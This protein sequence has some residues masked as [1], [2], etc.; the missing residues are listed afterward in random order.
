M[1]MLT[2]YAL[3]WLG[4]H[5]GISGTGLRGAIVGRIGPNA[6][7]GGFALAGLVILVML[8]RSYAT[9]PLVLMW[10]SPGWLRWV[11]AVVMLP[12]F[13]LFALSFARNPTSAGGDKLLGEEVRGVQRITRHPM[14]FAIAIWA[15]AHVIGTG[16]VASLVFFGTLFITAAAGMPSIDHKTAA[17]EPEGWAKF[18]GATSIV[19]FAAIAAGRN[20]FVPSEINPIVA[21]AGVALWVATLLLHRTVFGVAPIPF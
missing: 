19:P 11:L 18:A 12:T 16:D 6:F 8:C 2:I 1:T 7:R 17:R 14:M 3:I 5:I 13:V 10:I 15:A 21:L 4:L 20:R 9:S